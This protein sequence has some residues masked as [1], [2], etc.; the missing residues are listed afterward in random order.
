[1]NGAGTVDETKAN[2]ALVLQQNTSTG[3]KKAAGFMPVS[4]LIISKIKLKYYR[5]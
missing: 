5:N 4:A 3:Q 1:V 2:G